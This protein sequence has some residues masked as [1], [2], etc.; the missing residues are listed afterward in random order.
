MAVQKVGREAESSGTKMR[1]E[2]EADLAGDGVCA[3]G[4]RSAQDEHGEGM[5]AASA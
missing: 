2:M 1:T 3:G 5:Q 4:Q